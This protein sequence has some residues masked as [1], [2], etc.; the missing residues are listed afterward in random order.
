MGKAK[1]KT[2]MGRP[3]FPKG[4]VQDKLVVIRLTPAFHRALC[5]AAKKAGKCLT[6]FIRDALAEKLN[7]E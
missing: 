1:R 5:A 3:P 2:R 4:Q 6:H 7:E